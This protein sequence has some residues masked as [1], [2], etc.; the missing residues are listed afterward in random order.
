MCVCVYIIYE[1]QLYVCAPSVCLLP[2]VARSG[3][4]VPWSYKQ[5]LATVMEARTESGSLGRA[6]SACNH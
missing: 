5:L 6:V 1:C 2:V 4:W 3:F